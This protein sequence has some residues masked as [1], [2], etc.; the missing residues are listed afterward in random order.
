MNLQKL[1]SKTLIKKAKKTNSEKKYWRII[2][3]LRKR[4]TPT[5]YKTCVHLVY[6]KNIKE[7]LIGINILAQLSNGSTIRPY[8]KQIVKLFFKQLKTE[9]KGNNIMSLLYGIGHNSEHVEKR[10]IKQIIPFKDHPKSWVRE[11][12]T[13]ALGSLESKPSIHALIQLSKDKHDFIRDWATFGLANYETDNAQIR[14]A[15]W[16]RLSDKHKDTRSE[17]IYGLAK[18]KDKRI[19]KVLKKE[20]KDADFGVQTFDSILEY[21]SPIFV[22]KLET[23]YRKYKDD[24][25]TSKIWLSKL[26]NCIA[27]LKK[28]K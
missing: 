22:S 20:L 12:I 25:T 4:G 19:L 7:R 5:F 10:K 16:E 6:S 18:R 26:K 11:G 27:E 13:S 2:N 9:T 23:V 3:I 8:G 15:L 28:M 1:D 24:K 21:Q 17:A 14:S